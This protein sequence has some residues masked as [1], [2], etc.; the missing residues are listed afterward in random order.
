MKIAIAPLF[1][2]RTGAVDSNG[3]H[4]NRPGPKALLRSNSIPPIKIWRRSGELVARWHV[5][6]ETGRIECSWSLEE[7]PADDYL[8]PD[9]RRAL[10]RLLST[11]RRSSTQRR[12][13]I[14]GCHKPVSDRQQSRGL[15]P[16]AFGTLRTFQPH[17]RLPNGKSRH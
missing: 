1:V 13:A 2:I 17:R 14:A 9:F 11:W 4:C 12:P 3:S 6:P 8:C 10:R 15:S 5:S 7:P 16:A